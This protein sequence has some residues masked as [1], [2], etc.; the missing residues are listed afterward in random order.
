MGIQLPP[1]KKGAQPLPIFGDVYCGQTV[2]HLSYC[3]ALVMFSYQKS[4]LSFVRSML[5]KY[6]CVCVSCAV[7]CVDIISVVHAYVVCNYV[8][9]RDY[10]F[11]WFVGCLISLSFSCIMQITSG[12]SGDFLEMDFVKRIM[13][14][15]FPG[16][17]WEKFQNNVINSTVVTPVEYG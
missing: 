14:L 13:L 2:A 10:V 4:R 17:F 6:G 9:Q 5:V 1:R 11:I 3:W 12:F 8:C 15:R 7:C 16:W